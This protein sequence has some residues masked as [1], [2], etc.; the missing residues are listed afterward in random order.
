MHEI[1]YQK[2]KNALINR[3]K[4][5]EFSKAL[6]AYYFMDKAHQGQM[7]DNGE[8]Y[9]IHPISIA[10]N[11]L[12][13]KGLPK[14]LLEDL[15]CVVLM[16][17]TIEDCG[18]HPS[19]LEKEFGSEV[20]YAVKLMS[21]KGQGIEPMDDDKRLELMS[22]DIL[23]GLAK[24][25]DRC[26]NLEDMIQM[27]LKRQKKYIIESPK[28]YDMLKNLGKKF[29]EYDD[30]I[31]TIRQTIRMLVKMTNVNVNNCERYESEIASLKAELTQYKGSGGPSL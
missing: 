24:G 30:A 19:Q 3:L 5:M 22:E 9:A 15:L 13:L 4:G 6:K 14:E 10:L 26:N 28:I 21:K 23:T 20:A 31:M 18:V 12:L 25:V 27:S 1:S 8:P 16:H 29:P 17:D 7:R 2:R 11:V